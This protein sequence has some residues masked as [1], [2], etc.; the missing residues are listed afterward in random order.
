MTDTDVVA[1]SESLG[2]QPPPVPGV[3]TSAAL[4]PA[5]AAGMPPTAQAF[6]AVVNADGTLARGFQAASAA[7]LTTGTY[8]VV[9]T[10]DITGS[11]Y[12]GTLV[13]VPPPSPPKPGAVVR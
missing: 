7:K 12:V 13:I 1:R 10:H 3:D 5:T 8:Q 11:A 6:F 9:F 4:V 2:D